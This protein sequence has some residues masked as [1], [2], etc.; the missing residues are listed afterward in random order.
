MRFDADRKIRPDLGH[1]S[2]DVLAERQHIS[3]GPH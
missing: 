2:F 3:A 1:R